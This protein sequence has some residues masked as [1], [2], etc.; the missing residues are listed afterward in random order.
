MVA[1]T[2]PH[3]SS[4]FTNTGR[5]HRDDDQLL[6]LGEHIGQIR[7]ED[8]EFVNHVY[9]KLTEFM[10]NFNCTSSAQQLIRIRNHAAHVWAVIIDLCVM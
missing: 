3:C 5:V 4:L 6:S 10:Y 2:R 9:P 7:Q 8:G 1:E